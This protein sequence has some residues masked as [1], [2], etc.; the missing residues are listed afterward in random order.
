MLLNSIPIYLKIVYMNSFNLVSVPV[1]A[2]KQPFWKSPTTFLLQLILVYSPSSS[3][4][5]W[6]RPLIQFPI[7]SSSIDYPPSASLASP[8][9]GST[10]I[11][12]TAL[13]SS[14]SNPSVPNPP[15]SPLVSPRALSWVPSFS[16]LTSFPLALFS[17]NLIFFFTATRMT[18]SST[19]QPN[20]TL[21]SLLHPWQIAS[22]KYKPGSPQTSSNLTAIK[23]KSFYLVLNPLYSKLT[24]FPS[25]L[26]AP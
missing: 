23:Q 1:I 19:S 26:T 3:S 10:P 15:L 18:P 2:L 6:L 17:V 5:T 24:V 13:S 20:P 22:L 14:N 4:L 8:L 16:L 7:P 9:T 12:Q 21:S 25:H 11:S